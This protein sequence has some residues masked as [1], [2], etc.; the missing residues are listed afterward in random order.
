[1]QVRQVEQSDGKEIQDKRNLKLKAQLHTAEKHIWWLG[2]SV[3]L[4]TFW[5]LSP[6]SQAAQQREG[7]EASSLG[8]RCPL[9]ISVPRDDFARIKSLLWWQQ[10][11]LWAITVGC[12]LLFMLLKQQQPCW[13]C[14]AFHRIQH[15]VHHV[16][17]VSPEKK[18]GF[19]S[20]ISGN[21]LDLSH[22]SL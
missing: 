1:M 16:R 8:L 10:L 17:W 5:V 3:S 9:L 15:G 4:Q 7:E 2:C 13:H 12:N 14:R 20:L 22:S 19:I 18:K 6:L 11:L 21:C